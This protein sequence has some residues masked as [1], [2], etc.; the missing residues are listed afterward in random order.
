M[1]QSA[2]LAAAREFV[3]KRLPVDPTGHDWQHA[4]RV[5]KTALKIARSERADPFVVSL[6]ALLHDVDD[7]KFHQNGKKAVAWLKTRALD[8][9]LARKVCQILAEV[10]FKGAGVR[11]VPSSAEG[12]CV[13]DADRLDALGAIGIARAFAYGGYR[14]R[15]MYN[16]SVKPVLHRT[17]AQYKKNGGHT[18]AH[19]YEKLLL[20]KDRMNTK[21]GREMAKERH[22]YIK[23]FLKKFK[24]EWYN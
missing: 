2:M 7:W 17:F 13:Q 24:K 18:V 3:K 10:S 19:F 5:E 14:R 21:A 8:P 16:P 11:T 12:R 20:L 23:E 1:N 6:A 4:F 9:R 22:Q 15:P